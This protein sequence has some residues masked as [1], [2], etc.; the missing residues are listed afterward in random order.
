MLAINGGSSF[1]VSGTLAQISSGTLSGGTFVL[2]GSLKLGTG[3]SIATNSST[4]T[5][6]G[7]P[8]DHRRQQPEMMVAAKPA[9]ATSKTTTTVSGVGQHVGVSTHPRFAENGLR[10]ACWLVPRIL[11]ADNSTVSSF[12]RRVG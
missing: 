5:L 12:S 1:K 9:R 11:P 4:L 7:E 3:I 10:I 8:V 6:E 2:G